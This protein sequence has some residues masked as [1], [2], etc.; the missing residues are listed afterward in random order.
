MVVFTITNWQEYN[1]NCPR[2]FHG[3]ADLD[4]AKRY[5]QAIYN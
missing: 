5:M 1:P 4:A 3:M 2:V